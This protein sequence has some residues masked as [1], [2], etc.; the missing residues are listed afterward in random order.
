MASGDRY[1]NAF[2]T[3][4]GGVTDFVILTSKDLG[5]STAMALLIGYR[6][7]N[8]PADWSQAQNMSLAIGYRH[9]N[10]PGHWLQ[11]YRQLTQGDRESAQKKGTTEEEEGGGEIRLQC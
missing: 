10:S 4:P 6:H 8:K 11:A 2:G 1:R 3:L 7:R 9:R 5:S